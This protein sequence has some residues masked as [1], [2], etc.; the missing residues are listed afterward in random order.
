MFKTKDRKIDED[1]HVVLEPHNFA[2]KKTK[3]GR[4]DEIYFSKSSYVSVQDPYAHKMEK[5]MRDHVID[6]HLP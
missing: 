2:I 3:K 4:T 6:G 1:N 5:I